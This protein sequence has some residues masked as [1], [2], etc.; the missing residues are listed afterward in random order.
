[1][2]ETLRVKKQ[3]VS[4]KEKVLFQKIGGQWYVFR[5]WKGQAQ[6][7]ALPKNLNPKSSPLEIIE[8]IEESLKKAA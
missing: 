8:V 6:F 2:T 1:M 3:D 7:C 5:F 4:K